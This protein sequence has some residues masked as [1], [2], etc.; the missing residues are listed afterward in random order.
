MFI[1]LITL[2]VAC[3]ICI[4]LWYRKDHAL[5]RDWPP[6]SVIISIGFVDICS[7]RTMMLINGINADLRNVP[8]DYG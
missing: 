4:I 7:Y 2:I 3:M 8:Y 5:N 1:N 6:Q